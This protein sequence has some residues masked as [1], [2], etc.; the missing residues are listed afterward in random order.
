MRPRLGLGEYNNQEDAYG[1]MLDAL[2]E[3]TF[4]LNL[5]LSINE[6]T[7]IGLTYYESLYDRVLD[8]QIINTVT[9]GLGDTE[10]EL[11]DSDDDDYSGDAYYLNYPASNS[12]DSELNAMYSDASGSNH[13][14][15]LPHKWSWK[16]AKSSRMVWGVDFNTVIQ[17]IALQFEYAM[18]DKNREDMFDPNKG[19]PT[20]LIINGFWKKNRICIQYRST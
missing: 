20:A 2:T 16:E 10:P 15:R 9:G 19:H 1:N 13:F 8:P 6:G 11:D 4:G 14:K 17:N 3:R 18:M 12:A 5:R 7:N